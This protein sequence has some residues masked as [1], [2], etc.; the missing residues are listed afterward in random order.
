MCFDDEIAGEHVW[1]SLRLVEKVIEQRDG[2]VV[3]FGSAYGADYGIADK[4][5]VSVHSKSFR[6]SEARELRGFVENRHLDHC[7]DSVAQRNWAAIDV[8]GRLKRRE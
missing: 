5:G 8:A 4:D 7:R 3:P 1:E 6:D 2:F